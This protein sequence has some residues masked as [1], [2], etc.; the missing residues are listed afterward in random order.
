LVRA[1]HAFPRAVSL[2][3]QGEHLIRYTDDVLRKLN[4]SLESASLPRAAEGRD[5]L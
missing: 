5:I 3:I 4:L 1:R 2:A